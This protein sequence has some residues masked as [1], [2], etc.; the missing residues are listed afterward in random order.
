MSGVEKPMGAEDMFPPKGPSRRRVVR[1]EKCRSYL[2]DIDLVR[3][4]P[5]T[6][7]CVLI[8]MRCRN[9]RCR[10]P[11]QVTIDVVNEDKIESVKIE[12]PVIESDTKKETP[13]AKNA[14][15]IRPR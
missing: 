4:D 3:C 10:K 12:K 11:N 1:C 7:A 15:A 2:F 6:M 9:S 13:R 14:S 8:S 5:G